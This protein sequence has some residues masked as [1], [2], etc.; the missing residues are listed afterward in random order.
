MR[1]TLTSAAP[2]GPTRP[3]TEES[4]TR[5]RTGCRGR[6]SGRLGR[7]TSGSAGPLRIP[8]T[9]GL[10]AFSRLLVVY[11]PDERAEHLGFE[12]D[13]VRGG[14]PVF[15][16]QPD[17]EAVVRDVD[18]VAKVAASGGLR[19]IH[20]A[21]MTVVHG[22]PSIRASRARCSFKTGTMSRPGCQ[23]PAL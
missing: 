12:V 17:A 3:W 7:G 19:A 9:H 11:E 16:G 21:D 23:P 6:R 2:T 8:R 22:F 4:S 18:A 1:Q 15:G 14:E 13:R 10:A 20:G 5:G